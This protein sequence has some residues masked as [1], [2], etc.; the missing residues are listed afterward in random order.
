MTNFIARVKLYDWARYNRYSIFLDNLT[1]SDREFLC[2]NLFG[3]TSSIEITE[4]GG[5]TL[6]NWGPTDCKKA[7]RQTFSFLRDREL[8]RELVDTHVYD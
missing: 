6:Y 3:R 5:N 8:G 2:M 1:I 4:S 7:S